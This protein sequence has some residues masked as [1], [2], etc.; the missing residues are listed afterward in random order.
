MPGIRN[1]TSGKGLLSTDAPVESGVK[2]GGG[3][4][5][6][7]HKRPMGGSNDDGL[8]GSKSDPVADPSSELKK[9]RRNG[10]KAGY[11][12]FKM[13]TFQSSNKVSGA[14]MASNAMSLG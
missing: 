5:N 11:Y 8:G 2:S 6:D 4:L 3:M 7:Q 14:G 1:R 9:Q 13:P 10:Q 12:I